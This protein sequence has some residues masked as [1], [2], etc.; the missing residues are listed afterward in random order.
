MTTLIE[1][2]LIL[3]PLTLILSIGGWIADNTTILEKI[4]N[5]MED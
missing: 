1:M 2:I 3:S 4:I 5:K